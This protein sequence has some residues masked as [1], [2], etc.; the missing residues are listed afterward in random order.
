MQFYFRLR[1]KKVLLFFAEQEDSN[2]KLG[3]E[4]KKKSMFKTEPKNK[5]NSY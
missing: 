4:L 1:K 2:L 5:N 3:F